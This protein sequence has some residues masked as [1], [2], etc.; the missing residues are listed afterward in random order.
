MSCILLLAMML[1][2]PP[3]DPA[4]TV[5]PWKPPPS[6]YPWNTAFVAPQDP[7]ITDPPIPPGVPIDPDLAPHTNNKPGP[8]IET[9]GY[10]TEPEPTPT[11]P[12]VNPDWKPPDGAVGPNPYNP[13]P[14]NRGP[15]GAVSYRFGPCG[16]HAGG[17]FPNNCDDPSWTYTV[18][19]GDPPQW[20][21]PQP[22]P[23]R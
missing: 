23:A 11:L 18:P 7:S 15:A 5:P 6:N 1:I 4:P 10:A 13:W 14:S 17:D 19:P 20:W 8:P 16:G 22:V 3:L 21:T 12:P 2:A 9:D